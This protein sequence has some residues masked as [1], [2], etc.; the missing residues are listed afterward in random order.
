[1][2]DVVGG[3]VLGAAWVAV[4]A[5]AHAVRGTGRRRGVAVGAGLDQPR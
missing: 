4:M 5:A 2:S 3:L 1:V